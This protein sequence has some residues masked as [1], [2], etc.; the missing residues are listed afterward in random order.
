[1][2]YLVSGVQIAAIIYRTSNCDP[3]SGLIIEYSRDK[4]KWQLQGSDTSPPFS[5][6]SCLFRP[7]W[8]G[9]SQKRDQVYCHRPSAFPLTLSGSALAA[10][11]RSAA[12][13]AQVAVLQRAVAV[14]A[15]RAAGRN[16]LEQVLLRHE[17][18]RK[19]PAAWRHSFIRTEGD[20]QSQF[21]YAAKSI[22]CIHIYTHTHIYVNIYFF[23]SAA[24]TRSCAPRPFAAPSHFPSDRKQGAVFLHKL[25]FTTGTRKSLLAKVSLWVS[26][27]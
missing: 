24:R 6:L 27:Y 12:H 15:A 11:V 7:V 16:Q 8:A 17:A 5:F 19:R 18:A 23:P 10:L 14:V 2:I 9:R 21:S 1:M 25:R 13:G 20:K 22:V 3:L 4:L 26:N